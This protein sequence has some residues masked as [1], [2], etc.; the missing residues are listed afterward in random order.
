MTDRDWVHGARLETRKFKMGRCL[1]CRAPMTGLTGPE[2]DPEPGSVMVCAYCS[3]VMEWDGARLVPLSEEAIGDIAGDPDV[4]AVV[5]LTGE[6][7]KDVGP[8]AF[9]AA[10]NA[11]NQIGVIRCNRC[12]KPLVFPAGGP[13]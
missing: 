9:C 2:G 5:E 13:R 1:N 7:R 6:F 4:L 11:E 8:F 3:H 10:C 12:G